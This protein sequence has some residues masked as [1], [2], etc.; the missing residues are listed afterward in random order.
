[1]DLFG[2]QH[3][4]LS[5]WFFSMHSID[6]VIITSWPLW[7][8]GLQC[9][10][11]RLSPRFVSRVS[12]DFNEGVRLALSIKPKLLVV[13][14]ETKGFSN[15]LMQQYSRQSCHTVI[16]LVASRNGESVNGYNGWADEIIND[17]VAPSAVVKLVKRLCPDSGGSYER[18]LTDREMEIAGL[19][20][21]G[22]RTSEISAALYI[23]DNTV[24]TH[25]AHIREKLG[26]TGRLGIAQWY[27]TRG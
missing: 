6:T 24:K 12:G 20:A 19:I 11:S 18:V 8:L 2:K 21:E 7:N 15:S 26:V 10:L 4:A 14:S 13:G 17:V 27:R 16:I 1:M 23:S 9:T 22:H 5:M 25:L 3:L